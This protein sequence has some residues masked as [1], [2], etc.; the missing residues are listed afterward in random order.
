ML[1][2]DGQKFMQLPC[3]SMFNEYVLLFKLK[4]NIKFKAFS[5]TFSNEDQMKAVEN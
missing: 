4:S 3:D 1:N 5:P 2:K